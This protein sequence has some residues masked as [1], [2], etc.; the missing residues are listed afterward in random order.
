[1]AL[2]LSF[3]L[4]HLWNILGHGCTEEVLIIPLGVLLDLIQGPFDLA[5]ALRI[6]E[7]IKVMA[8]T[9]FVVLNTEQVIKSR[10]GKGD[11]LVHLIQVV[12]IHRRHELTN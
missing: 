11:R 6:A 9:L 2:E 5:V 10:L 7:M 4:L 12:W 1:M 3:E 8:V